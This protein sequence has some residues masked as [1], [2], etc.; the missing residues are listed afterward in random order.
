MYKDDLMRIAMPKD[1]VL[2]AS[3]AALFLPLLLVVIAGLT[4]VF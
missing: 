3:S 4:H 1:I 2:L